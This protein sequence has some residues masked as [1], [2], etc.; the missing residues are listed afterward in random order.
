MILTKEYLLLIGL[1]KKKSPSQRV[2]KAVPKQY[3]HVA[4][5]LMKIPWL[6]GN[7]IALIEQ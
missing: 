1:L 3:V 7:I 4:K 2:G 5:K 6:L